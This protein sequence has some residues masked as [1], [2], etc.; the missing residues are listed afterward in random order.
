MDVRFPFKRKKI[1]GINQ[2]QFTYVFFQ[3][4]RLPLFCFLC[5][6]LGHGESYYQVRLT[7]RNQQVEFGW[8]SSLRA[9]PRRGGQAVSKWLREENE[10]EKWVR[11]DI[12]GER[13]ERVFGVDVTNRSIYKEWMGSLGHF[14]RKPR[15]AK[16]KGLIGM[17]KQ[18]MGVEEDV[19]L[20]DLTVEF[21]NG[22]KRQRF[23]SDGGSGLMDVGS[24][25][26]ISAT[27]NKLVDRA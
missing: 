1:I 10:A 19:K 4:E 26:M 23:H 13:R 25:T 27:N 14:N 21:V 3:Y 16:D 18:D 2:S 17:S 24:E 8:D 20:E 5:G 12:D 7:L 9:A 11:M 15:L 22:K 6:C